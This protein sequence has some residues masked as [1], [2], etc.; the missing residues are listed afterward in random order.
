MIL[1]AGFQLENRPGRGGGANAMYMYMET[2]EGH[3]IFAV[4][5]TVMD[6]QGGEGGTNAPPITPQMKPRVAPKASNTERLFL[7][8]LER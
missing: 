7:R 2:V 5:V 8:T 4:S 1:C 3:H 6:F